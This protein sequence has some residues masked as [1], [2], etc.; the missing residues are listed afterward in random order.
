M[1]RAASKRSR[2]D[3]ILGLHG[4]LISMSG[5][6]INQINHTSLGH[7][8]SSIG[9]TKPDVIVHTA[10]ITSIDICEISPKNAY[11]V[12]VFWPKLL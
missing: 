9:S 6:V 11:A 8:L 5:D 1:N 7:V 3:I 10:G 12:N 2:H 4:K